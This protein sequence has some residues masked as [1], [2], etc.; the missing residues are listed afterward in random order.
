M[1]SGHRRSN[2]NPSGTPRAVAPFDNDAV[3]AASRC[4]DG[5]TGNPVP[6]Q[7]VKSFAEVL[8]LYHLHPEAKFLNADYTDCGETL[9]HHVL[10][11]G[12]H[13]IGKE[14]NRWEEQV[15]LGE[16]S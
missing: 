12:L 8:A 16:D 2:S 15:Y 10:V 5:T 13:H 7:H 6:A 14:A 9:R 3:T 4:F 1:R 11:D